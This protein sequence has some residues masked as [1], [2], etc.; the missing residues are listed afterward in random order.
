MDEYDTVEESTPPS[1]DI[2]ANERTM[3]MLCHLLALSGY[4]IPFGN[5]IGPLVMW[6]V[7]KDEMPFVDEQGKE[8][9]NFQITV[10]IAMIVSF[11]LVFVIIGFFLLIAIGIGS[12]VLVIIATIKAN[13]GTHYRYPLTIRLIK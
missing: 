10:M 7:K 8:S 4:V 6:L 9:L 3:A 2:P 1:G 12:L 11:V 13:E 5:I